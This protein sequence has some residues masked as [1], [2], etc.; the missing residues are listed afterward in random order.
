VLDPVL[1]RLERRGWSRGRA[2]ATVMAGFIA[3]LGL[4]IVLIVP[5]LVYQVR[6]AANNYAEY[7]GKAQTIYGTW[8]GEIEL[9]VRQHV[10]SQ[11]L[12]PLL[13]EKVAEGSAWLQERLPTFLQWLSQHLISSLGTLVMGVL[14]LLISFHFMMIIDPF[15]RGLRELLPRSADAEVNR[16]SVEINRML[17]Q[18][19]RGVV[20]VSVS[21]AVT[22]MLLLAIVGLFFGTKYGLIIGL[23]TGLTCMVP[24]FGPLLSAVSAGVTG[25]VTAEQG[26]PWIA[27]LVSVVAMVAQNQVFDNVVTPRIV[28]RKVG[29][30]PLVVLLAA[31]IGL[32]LFGL[33]GMIIA[34]PAAACVKILL[35]RWLPVHGP[36]LTTKAPHAKLE[37][38]LWHGL[39]VVGQGVA[40]LRQNVERAIGGQ[41]EAPPTAVAAGPTDAAEPAAPPSSPEPG[42]AGQPGQI[43]AKLKGIKDDDAA[44]S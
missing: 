31:M 1:D 30:H 7:S 10:P 32:S 11:D 41:G 6:D 26:S 20:V 14:L 27:G 24:Y 16:V 8:R 28:G 35:A 19:L 15:R 18:Y 36:D 44:D 23:V 25:L 29:L 22:A 40:K 37:L 4:A 13:D 2:V 43:A 17:A 39:R 21:Q 3:A 9:Y 33:W 5:Q 34:T 12:M 42:P 38:D